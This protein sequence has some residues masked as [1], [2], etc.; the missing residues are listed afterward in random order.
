MKNNSI[1][2]KFREILAEQGKECS[3]EEAAEIYKSA[4]RIIEKS[5]RLS[6]ID[7]WRMQNLKVEGMT[8]EEKNQAISLY[9]HAR[10]IG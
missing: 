5:K 6:Q 7:L 9:Q 8:E 10:D 2:R 1:I 4:R 3:I